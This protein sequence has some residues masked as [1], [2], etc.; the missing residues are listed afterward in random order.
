MGFLAAVFGFS[1]KHLRMFEI[2]KQSYQS[3]SRGD[4]LYKLE[5]TLDERQVMF[6]IPNGSTFKFNVD[7]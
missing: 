2:P 4:S 3:S 7:D 6:A 1:G 5:F